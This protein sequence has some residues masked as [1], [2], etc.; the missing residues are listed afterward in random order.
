MDGS[1]F[2]Q[3]SRMSQR[4]SS[5]AP[6]AGRWGIIPAVIFI[7]TAGVTW[8]CSKGL[9][10]VNTC[11]AVIPKLQT[12]QGVLNADAVSWTS[13]SG[14]C[15]RQF[16]LRFHSEETSGLRNGVA[17]P[18]SDNW[19]RQSS[20]MKILEPLTSPCTIGGCWLCK[21]LKAK[22]SW[23]IRTSLSAWGCCLVYWR[24]FH[25]ICGIIS[26]GI[27]FWSSTSPRKGRMLRC[28]ETDFH[29]SSCLENS[30]NTS[31][32]GSSSN[33]FEGLQS[34][35]AMFWFSHFAMWMF[36]CRVV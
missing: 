22:D 25:F 16:S 29:L 8:I 11:K 34:F 17:I 28:D 33:F 21:Y 15:Q 12:S 27:C 4:S 20:E 3:F 14:A 19:R 31:S 1:N 30:F 6:V 23:Y 7:R 36:V 26:I 2:Q 24:I 18:M 5:I 10:P 13:S 9:L 35:S 32:S